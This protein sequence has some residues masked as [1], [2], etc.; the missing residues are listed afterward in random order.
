MINLLAR[1]MGPSYLVCDEMRASFPKPESTTREESG[2]VELE[3]KEHTNEMKVL[4]SRM[5]VTFCSLPK[6][7]RKL[8]LLPV[9]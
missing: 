5:I 6:N 9:H 1:L 2:E 8:P 7:G 3:G 4:F